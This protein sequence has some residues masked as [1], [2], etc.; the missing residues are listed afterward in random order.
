VLGANGLTGRSK[1]P[2]AVSSTAKQVPAVQRRAM[3]SALGST[4]W[5]LLDSRVVVMG[6]LGL[7]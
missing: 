5:P 1:T 2:S 3:R 4:I 6:R 7:W